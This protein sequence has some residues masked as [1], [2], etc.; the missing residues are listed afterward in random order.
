M[1]HDKQTMNFQRKYLALLG[2]LLPVL[3]PLLGFIAK[4]KNAPD[5]WYS[6]SATYYASSGWIM[7]GILFTFACFLL[8]YRGYDIGDRATCT[9]S[10]IMALSILIFPCAC[11]AAGETV[12]ILNLP[13]M[14]SH[15]VHC[16]VAMALFGSFAYM[17][18]FRFT[19]SD[20]FITTQKETRN[21]IYRACGI[22]IIIFMINQIVTSILNIGWFTIINEAFML[23]AFSFAWAVKA[24][25]FKKLNEDFTKYK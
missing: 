15:G 24:G 7:A 23:W 1:R 12:G 16:T 13:R 25:C 21:K 22:L 5:F 10:G 11:S 14:V 6:I 9:F 3:A 4:D 2:I 20:G 19:K 17:I 18:F 8:S